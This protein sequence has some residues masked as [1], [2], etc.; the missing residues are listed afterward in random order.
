[1]AVLLTRHPCVV[2]APGRRSA[3]L[4]ALTQIL[5]MTGRNLSECMDATPISSQHSHG[6]QRPEW[7]G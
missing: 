1:M 3:G 7:A 4:T 2:S 6:I 5:V